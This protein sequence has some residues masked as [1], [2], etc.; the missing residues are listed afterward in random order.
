MSLL[1][2]P[3]SLP[4]KKPSPPTRNK[5]PMMRLRCEALTSKN[6]AESAK[7]TR[8]HRSAT[9][10]WMVLPV[11]SL[12]WTPHPVLSEAS[13]PVMVESWTSYRSMPFS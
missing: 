12:R 4:M 1:G 7:P 8:M 9:L 10:L 11:D 3:C 2:H 6:P 5:L 13:L